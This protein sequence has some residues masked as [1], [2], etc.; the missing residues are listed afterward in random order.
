MGVKRRRR[1]RVV[2]AGIA[3]SLAGSI[4][5]YTRGHPPAGAAGQRPGHGHGRDVDRPPAAGGAPAACSRVDSPMRP[6]A[7]LRRLLR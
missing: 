4:F 1:G 6:R 5:A 7:A 2:S 3:A